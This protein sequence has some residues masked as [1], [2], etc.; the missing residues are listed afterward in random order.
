MTAYG[1]ETALLVVDVQNDFADP[2]GNLSV[3]GGDEIVPFVNEQVRAARA[4]GSLVAYTQDWHPPHTPHFAQDGGIW[5]VHCVQDTWGAELHPALDVAGPV[6]QKGSH[7]EDGYSGFTMRDVLTGETMP[8]VLETLLRDA[9]AERV[10]ICGLATDYCVRATSLD[11][12]RL[13]FETTVLAAGIRAVD[14][15]PGDGERALAEIAAAGVT[16]ERFG[17]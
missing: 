15:Q 14:L 7:G 17:G 9:D 13:G 6:V 4:A 16:V 5:P 12:L 10:V 3:R 11:A 8:T 2:S 1:P